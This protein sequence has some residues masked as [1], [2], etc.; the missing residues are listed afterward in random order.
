MKKCLLIILLLLCV[1]CSYAVAEEMEIACPQAIKDL[2]QQRYGLF[3]VLEYNGEGPYDGWGGNKDGAFAFLIQHDDDYRFVIIESIDS[4]YCITAEQLYPVL[5]GIVPQNISLELVEEQNEKGQFVRNYELTYNYKAPDYNLQVTAHSS[6]HSSSWNID[7]L[8]YLC[9]NGDL[10]VHLTSESL[11]VHELAFDGFNDYNEWKIPYQGVLLPADFSSFSVTDIYQQFHTESY[12][13]YLI[14]NAILWHDPFVQSEKIGEIESDEYVRGLFLL[15][16]WEY[17]FIPM[18]ECSGFIHTSV[19]A[20]HLHGNFDQCEI[21]LTDK[22]YE[23]YTDELL[24]DAVQAAKEYFNDAPYTL[25]KIEYDDYF[26]DELYLAHE[27]K[28]NYGICI[29]PDDDYDAFTCFKVE[30]EIQDLRYLF[31]YEDEAWEEFLSL[32]HTPQ[33]KWI[34]VDC[35]QP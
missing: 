13:T 23:R 17:V 29:S 34:C 3:S 5:N 28:L 1:L 7:A 8:F 6:Q 27:G 9:D 16:D 31:G 15:E 33:G 26:T 2:L 35:G 18:P 22:A 4:V 32:A 19:L 10:L 14:D 30:W 21:I 25:R 20:P 12:G 11:W 24:E